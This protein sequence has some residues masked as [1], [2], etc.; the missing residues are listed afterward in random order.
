MRQHDER[1]MMNNQKVIEARKKATAWAINN[2]GLSENEKNKLNAWS[3][4]FCGIH[5]YLDHNRTGAIKEA[6]DA[7]KLG[8][9]NKKY[10]L[11][12]AKSVIGRK[13]IKAIQ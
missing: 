13:L 3:H 6:M 7:I 2:L 4:Y 10:L 8:G 5:Q 12:F 9:L 1:S 11:L